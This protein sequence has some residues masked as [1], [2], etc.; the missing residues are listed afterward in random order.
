[1]N[2]ELIMVNLNISIDDKSIF[3]FKMNLNFL[4]M[5]L[6]NIFF[7]MQSTLKSLMSTEQQMQRHFFSIIKA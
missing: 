6:I 1:M 3:Y 4:L 7:T 2:K 5:Y